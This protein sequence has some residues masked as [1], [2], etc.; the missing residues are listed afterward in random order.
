MEMAW[1]QV[2]EVNVANE[3]IRK[4]QMAVGTSKAIYS[5]HIVGKIDQTALTPLADKF[6]RTLKLTSGV[7]HKIQDD[8]L[9]LNPL[10]PQSGSFDY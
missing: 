7:L 5:K 6:E 1:N 2:G 3:K 10:L 9:S 8:T 4:A